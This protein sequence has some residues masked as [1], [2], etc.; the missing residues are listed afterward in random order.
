MYHKKFD[1]SGT[2]NNKK[3]MELFLDLGDVRVMA[4]VRLNGKDLGILWTSPW[5]VKVTEALKEKGN[6]LEIEVV[7]LWGNRLIGDEN[8]PWDGIENGKWPEW[9]LKKQPR[10]SGRYTFTT[11]HYYKKNMPLQKS[12]LL[13]PVSIQLKKYGVQ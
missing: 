13:G 4:K 5:Q 11:Y 7:N 3:G 12:G 2:E 6:E 1:F 10:T 9:L 8:K